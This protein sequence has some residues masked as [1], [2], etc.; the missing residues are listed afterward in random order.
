SA[1][2][3]RAGLETRKASLRGHNV[4]IMVD[5][6]TASPKT[7]SQAETAERRGI[8]VGRVASVAQATPKLAIA[9]VANSSVTT[10]RTRTSELGWTHKAASPPFA[11]PAPTPKQSPAT[12]RLACARNHRAP[13]KNIKNAAHGAANASRRRPIS[14]GNANSTAAASTPIIRLRIVNC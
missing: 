3:L 9:G 8:A 11:R 2:R 5:G 4:N 13:T 6:A 14:D 10:R 12:R 7:S 1:R